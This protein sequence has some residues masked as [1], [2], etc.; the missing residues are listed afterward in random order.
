MRKI[1]QDVYCLIKIN[2]I[3]LFAIIE[4]LLKL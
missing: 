2:Y 3:E 1:V 4:P